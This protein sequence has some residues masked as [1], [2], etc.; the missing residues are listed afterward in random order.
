MLAEVAVSQ[1]RFNCICIQYFKDTS[2]YLGR[3]KF[4]HDLHVKIT[5]SKNYRIMSISSHS[6]CMWRNVIANT[7]LS[8]GNYFSLCQEIVN[9]SNFNIYMYFHM[10]SIRI[11]LQWYSCD[12]FI[13]KS[14]A[15]F[16]I[17]KCT[18]LLLYFVNYRSIWPFLHKLVIV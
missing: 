7:W 17:V 8:Y 14:L 1:G 6:Q 9:I 10:Q 13:S 2:H 3:N 15:N 16:N 11:W 18:A 12:L 5:S 4:T